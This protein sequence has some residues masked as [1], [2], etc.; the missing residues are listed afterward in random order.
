MLAIN[1]NITMYGRLPVYKI[2]N[3]DHYCVSCD[4]VHARSFLC[5]TLHIYPTVTVV[6][7][8]HGFSQRAI[9][10]MNLI[11]EPSIMRLDED[12]RAKEKI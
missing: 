8:E 4:R 6:A 2:Q 1:N 3:M 11:C 7:R 12:A 9:S 10:S 5:G